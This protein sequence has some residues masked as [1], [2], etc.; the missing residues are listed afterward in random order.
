LHYRA[1]S[2]LQGLL[3]PCAQTTRDALADAETVGHPM[4]L[5]FSLVW[6]GCTVSIGRG[7]LDTAGNSIARLKDLAEKHGLGGYYASGLGFEGQ[8]AARRGDFAAGERLLRASLDGLRQTRYE[9]HY[10]P[11][12]ASLAE[13]LAAAGHLDESLAAVDEALARAV[14]SDAFWWMPELLRVK[15]EVLLS[16]ADTTAAADH[17]H[18]SL[19]LAH[20]QG[21]YL[22]NCAPP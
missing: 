12:L 21:L 19:D 14:R 16:L 11:F 2:L 6:C 8:L 15:G 5:C 3:D 10:G 22:G 4:S 17:F 1:R 18:R 20:R 7:D 13:V 9:V